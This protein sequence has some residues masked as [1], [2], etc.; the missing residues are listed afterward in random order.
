MSR[1]RDER[2]YLT[3]KYQN[4]QKRLHRAYYGPYYDEMRYYQNPVKNLMR[5][6]LGIK[7][8]YQWEM[9]HPPSALEVAK[10]KCQSWKHCPCVMC[11]SPRRQ[12][13]ST[14]WDKI[15]QQERK[16]EDSYKEQLADLSE[17]GW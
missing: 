9:G 8:P 12:P 5:I 6:L 14:H 11:K 15:T 17:N 7:P 4:R 2:M 3:E 10:W 13:W 1:T 16:G